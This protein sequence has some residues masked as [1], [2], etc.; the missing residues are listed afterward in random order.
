MQCGRGL[1][2]LGTLSFVVNWTRT[3]GSV[4]G[5]GLGKHA[6]DPPLKVAG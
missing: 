4:Y 5:R 6:Y 3:N 1:T 2:H